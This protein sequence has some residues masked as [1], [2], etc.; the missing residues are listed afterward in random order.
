MLYQLL[1]RVQFSFIFIF[2]SS[3]SLYIHMHRYINAMRPHASVRVSPENPL[4]QS[5]CFQFLLI[6]HIHILV[7][8]NSRE[9]LLQ[10]IHVLIE[11]ISKVLFMEFG[12][13][14]RVGDGN[15]CGNTFPVVSCTICLDIIT[16]NGD[17]S[18]VK[19]QC[20]HQFHLGNCGDLI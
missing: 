16:D 6:L 17:R 11:C 13:L 1:L 4:V 18:S 7:Y 2:F 9:L 20:G 19:L 10:I 15:G 14:N 8:Y 5:S 12:D 3:L